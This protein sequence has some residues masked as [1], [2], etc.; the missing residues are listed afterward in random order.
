MT[1]T[2]LVVVEEQ[3]GGSAVVDGDYGSGEFSGGSQGRWEGG[4]IDRTPD[5]QRAG[6][7]GLC[8]SDR[9]RDPLLYRPT[10]ARC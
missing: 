5:K 10:A 9:A 6:R 4:A 2:V 8:R 3:F 1:E 7:R